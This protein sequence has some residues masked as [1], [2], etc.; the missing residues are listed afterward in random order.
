[1]ASGDDHI[2]VGAMPQ[3]VHLQCTRQFDFVV[4]HNNKKCAPGAKSVIHDDAV[5]LPFN[6]NTNCTANI[7]RK[8]WIDDIRSHPD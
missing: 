5:T 6:F 7:V 1:M 2:D 4:V 8:Q 3:H